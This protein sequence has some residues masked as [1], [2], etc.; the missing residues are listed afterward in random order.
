MSEPLFTD[1]D[2]EQFKKPNI[3]RMMYM[4]VLCDDARKL[5]FMS[6]GTEVAEKG[7]AC[8]DEAE[9]RFALAPPSIDE[10]HVCSNSPS[11]RL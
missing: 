4:Q 1:E 11:R 7:R 8:L 5:G 3:W 10:M 6:G 9:R 2:L